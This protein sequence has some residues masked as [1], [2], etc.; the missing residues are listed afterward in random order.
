VTPM[1]TG[2]FVVIRHNMEVAHR[3]W[4][5]D[6]NKCQHIH[7]HSMWVEL[8]LESAYEKGG[9][10]HNFADQPLEFGDIK[11]VFRKHLDEE[12]DHRLLL[13]QHD[14]WAKSLFTYSNMSAAYN[15]TDGSFP[16][17]LVLPGL[18]PVPD[19][20]T[21]ENIAKWI[22]AWSAEVFHV[23]VLVRVNETH[24]NAAIAVGYGVRSGLK[25]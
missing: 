2:T 22:A 21:T 25:G 11:S 1:N 15:S 6:G 5:L 14:P 10:A 17:G 9:I 20:P 7:G 3:L 12:Y 8:Q 19:D 23:D 13:N 24:T 16:S 18:V 4:K